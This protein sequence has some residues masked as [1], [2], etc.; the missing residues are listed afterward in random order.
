[1]AVDVVEPLAKK[2]LVL[3]LDSMEFVRV[4][5]TANPVP[6]AVEW[7]ALFENVAVTGL[8]DEADWVVS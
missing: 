6:V 7:L 4:P 2:I 1:M 8:D 5:F 3:R